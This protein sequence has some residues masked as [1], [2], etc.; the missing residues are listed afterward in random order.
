MKTIVYWM[1]FTTKSA[2]LSVT[3]A[4]S[5]AFNTYAESL[6]AFTGDA[7]KGRLVFAQCRTCHYPEK[8]VGHHNGPSLHAIFGK[9]AGKQAGFDDYS[10]TF[11]MAQFVWTE[12]LLFAWLANVETMF[13]ETTMMSLGVKDPQ[14]RADLIAY[15]KRFR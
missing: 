13:P 3:V 2:V 4:F 11:K 9:V 8:I 14:Q 15:L 12:D 7:E 5:L 1:F 10:E 6:D